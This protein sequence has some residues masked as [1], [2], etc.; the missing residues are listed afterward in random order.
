MLSFLNT[1]FYIF[2]LQRKRILQLDRTMGE[3][4]GMKIGMF[5]EVFHNLMYII[6]LVPKFMITMK[7][8]KQ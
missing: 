4:G 3:Y 8:K 2:S 5:A 7:E 6:S 1:M